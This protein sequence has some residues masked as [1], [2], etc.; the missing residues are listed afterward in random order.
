[1]KLRVSLVF[2]S[3][4]LVN[5]LSGYAQVPNFDH[6]FVIV[7]ENQ[8]YGNVIGNSAAPYINSLAQQYGVATNDDAITHPSL[9]NYMALTSGDTY[10][11]DDC[12]GCV[13]SAANI[14]DRIEASGRT[15]T[16]YME[17]LPS[18]CAA[19]DS[20]SYTARHNPFVHYSDIVSNSARCN[21]HIVPFSNFA[22]DLSNGTLANYV[23]ITPNLCHD[24]HDCSVGSGDAWLST[25]VPQILQSPSFRNSVLILAWDEGVTSTGGGGQV[26]L[27]VASP[28]TPAG[29]QVAVAVNHYSLLRTIED[30]WQLAPLGQSAGATA[31]TSFFPRPAVTSSD[32]VIYASD[33]TVVGGLWHPV[34]DSTAAGGVKLSTPDNGVAALTAP[35][36]NPTDYFEAA[37]NAQSGTR[38]RVWLRIHAID[39]SKWNDSAFVQ[40]SDSVDAGSNPVYRIGTSNG[41]MVNLWTCATCQSIGWGWQRNAY[42][43]ADS[44]DVW[45]PASG[46]H[47]LRVQAREDGVEIDQIVISPG[48][49]ATNP[50]GA[51][52]HDTTIVPKPSTASPPSA[53]A[54]P[55]PVS[56]ATGVSTSPT[57][58][59]MAANAASY[60]VRLGQTNQ[61]PQVAAN[62]SDTSYAPSA[63]AANTTYFWQVV[64]HNSVGATAGPVWSFTT[65]PAPASGNVVV[66]ASDIPASSL[67]GH[68]T[69]VSDATSPNGVKLATPDNGIANTDNALAS[70]ADYIDVTVTAAAGTP[71][72]HLAAHAGARQLE[73]E[74]LAVAAVLR[75]E[76][77]RRSGLPDR[78]DAGSAPESCDG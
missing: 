43:L 56:G 28:Y 54:N 35:L 49:Y 9:P 4:L 40:F 69:A 22:A 6:V 72:T 26:P 10:F 8:E 39:D 24:M 3:V 13:T 23:W 65:A 62:L 44:G 38:Y 36:A 20:G 19:T 78:H 25:V 15:W 73:M 50:P 70:P 76:G 14:A 12:T 77:G 16:A 45:F 66:Y 60:D 31:M 1:M 41:L 71:Y 11:T 30:A 27:V 55:G 32:Q 42:W 63:L 2:L 34:S 75:C 58:T 59:W 57:L 37:F 5:T 74:R 53:P 51:V 17:D 61:P 68:W 52:S 21:S 18:A 48:A 67:H 33:A 47:T 46:R 7:M 64:A 29:T